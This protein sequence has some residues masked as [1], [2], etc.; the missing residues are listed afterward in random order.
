MLENFYPAYTA[1][2]VQR[3]L[4]AGGRFVGKTNMDE[5]AMGSG[6]V[7]SIFGPVKNPWDS[8]CI[9]GGSSGGSAVAVATR[10]VDFALGSDT[11][12]SVRNP[13]SY[14]G[15]VGFKPSYGT[16]SRHGLISLLNSTDVPAIFSRTVSDTRTVFNVISGWDAKDSTTFKEPFPAPKKQLKQYSPD[17]P[18]LRIGIP[19]EFLLPELF[20]H[21]LMPYKDTAK[22]LEL[23]GADVRPI[24][25]P[26]SEYANACYA[27]LCACDVASN[28]ARYDGIEFGHR[29]QAVVRGRILAGNYF[30]LKR[31]YSAYFEQA[32]KVRRLIADDFQRVFES[33]QADVILA[34]VT[35]GEAPELDAFCGL[36]NRTQQELQD[37]FTVGASL[38]GL[39]AISLPI[40]LSVKRQ[41]PVGMQLIAPFREDL[42]LLD[43][44]E[45]LETSLRTQ[46][47]VDDG[48]PIL[49]NYWNDRSQT[50]GCV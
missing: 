10:A 14:C 22:R 19:R 3:L 20:D 7:D 46:F 30:L 9:A 41:L 48:R 36:D 26:H 28:M 29:S 32:A 42:F 27:V 49:E 12:G 15:V 13:A 1:T 11:G 6:S 25:L 44:A 24:S 43:V 34:P 18:K 2:V 21:N 35:L 8:R 40:G 5:F 38:A 4:D 33:G 37:W 23:L 17:M 50:Y 45:R 39:P 47:G 16:V 31:N